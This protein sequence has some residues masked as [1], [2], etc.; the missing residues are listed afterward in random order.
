[1][2]P[3]PR[4]G[5]L[6]GCGSLGDLAG[7]GVTVR[8]VPGGVLVEVR[9]RPRSRPEWQIA[10]GALVVRVAGAPV[11]GAATE[12][13]RRALDKAL[14]VAPSRVSL[15]RGQRSRTKV[16]AAAGVDEEAAR[17]A[18]RRAASDDPG[19]GGPGAVD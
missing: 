14:G 13:A 8:A 17:T 7:G 19:A 16:F 15:Q 12:E 1:V 3:I 4:R 10:A 11:G 6:P 9:V 18:L 5:R 2:G